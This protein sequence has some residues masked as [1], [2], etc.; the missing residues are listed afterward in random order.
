MGDEAQSKPGDRRLRAIGRLHLRD[1]RTHVRFR[2]PE[3]D[4][5]AISNL[6]VA[7][8]LSEQSKNFALTLR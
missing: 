1:D 4:T 2:R 6:L 5:T 3:P 7:E 8:A